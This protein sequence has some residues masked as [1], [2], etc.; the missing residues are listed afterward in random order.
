MALK[1]TVDVEYVE[2]VG[3]PHLACVLLLDTSGSMGK[4]QQNPKIS[5]LNKGIREFK[6][7]VSQDETAKS[8]VDVAIVEFNNEVRIIQDFVPLNLM[9]TPNLGAFGQTAMGSGI[10]TAI[11]LV[12]T[13]VNLYKSKG[14]DAY[15]PYILMISDGLPTDD[16]TIARTLVHE[17]ETKNK[18]RFV[19]AGVEGCDWGILESLTKRTIDIRKPKAFEEFFHWWSQVV[20]SVSHSEDVKNEDIPPKPDSDSEI[21]V[22]DDFWNK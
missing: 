19:A 12:R 14:I 20:I 6:E 5:T 7:I 1:Q 9:D 13:R 3:E 4:P 15:I 22:G 2:S 10:A 21:E 8:C 11:E 16:I 18:L 17:R